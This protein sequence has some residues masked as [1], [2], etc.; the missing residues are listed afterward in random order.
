LL[1][2]GVEA[3]LEMVS[4][5]KRYFEMFFFLLLQKIYLQECK[6]AIFFD[7]LVKAG[8]WL[9]FNSKM[10]CK[11][12]GSNCRTTYLNFE[13]NIKEKLNR[14]DYLKKTEVSSGHSIDIRNNQLFCL[15][16]CFYFGKRN[17]QFEQ[18]TLHSN[19]GNNISI[20]SFNLTKTKWKTRFEF[21]LA[22]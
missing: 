16:F 6:T 11:K 4:W 2:E 13:A 12:N 19:E 5:S 20:W 9:H 7:R 18:E 10:I 3:E 17:N 15:C 1:R 14:L 21:F 22:G 8:Q